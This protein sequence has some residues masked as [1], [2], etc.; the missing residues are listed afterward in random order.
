MYSYIKLE[1]NVK[2]LISHK[3]MVYKLYK[4]YRLFTIFVQI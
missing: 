2:D 4:W 1:L 3:K